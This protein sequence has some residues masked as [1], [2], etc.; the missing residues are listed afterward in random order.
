MK[1]KRLGLNEA[2]FARTFD[3]I[4]NNFSK[5]HQ[6]QGL[7]AK[8]FDMAKGIAWW[9]KN[10]LCGAWAME[11]DNGRFVASIGLHEDAPW[12]SNKT[13]L[14]DGWFYVRPEYRKQNVG[15]VLVEVAKDFA[16]ERGMTLM[17]GIFHMEDIEDKIKAF[18]RMGMKLA[19][20]NF[21]A[22]E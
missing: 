20:A 17:I 15:T 11:D 19:S 1:I 18:E 9:E 7:S 16:A 5:E 21:I 8:S 13:F 3:L 22:G 6:M 4:A 10:V 2:D 12:Y 14:T